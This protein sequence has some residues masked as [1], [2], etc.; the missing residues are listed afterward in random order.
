MAPC[1]SQYWRHIR[2][3]SSVFIPS[4]MTAATASSTP[5]FTTPALRMPSICSGVLISSR[6]GT[7]L[8]LFSQY[9][10]VLSI[11]VG[12]CPLRQCHLLFFL[13]ASIYLI[14]IYTPFF[15]AAKVHIK[16]YNN[17]LNSKIMPT[18]MPNEGAWKPNSALNIISQTIGSPC[19][20]STFFKV[21]LRILLISHS[22]QSILYI[23]FPVT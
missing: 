8:P 15:S 6:V 7:S 12:S 14:N 19:L 23:L 3:I 21:H 11:S 18:I 9:M 13:K 17:K 10:M 4:W 2:S 16:Y 5:V 1:S 22:R 20:L